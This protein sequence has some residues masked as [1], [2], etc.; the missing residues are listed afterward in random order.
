MSLDSEAVFNERV[1]ALGLQEHTEKFHRLGWKTYGSLAFAT[2]FV[3]GQTEDERFLKDIVEAGLGD[4]GH[5]HK[6]ALRRLFFESYT[7]AAADL[8]RKVEVTTDDAPRKVPAAERQERRDR[9]AIRLI[10]ISLR[11]ELDISNRLLDLAV[12]IYEENTMRYV[13]WQEC[14]KREM[15]L[16]G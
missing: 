16:N 11:G 8:K 3:P 7:L 5:H 2:S 9:V 14:T 13:S 6:G 15:E 1:V 12:G 10:G 4:S